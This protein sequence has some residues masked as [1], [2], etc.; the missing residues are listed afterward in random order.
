MTA[1]TGIPFDIPAANRDPSLLSEGPISLPYE[2]GIWKGLTDNRKKADYRV[3]WPTI[4]RDRKNPNS[5][6]PAPR[7]SNVILQCSPKFANSITRSS[8]EQLGIE[9]R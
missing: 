2:T 4:L 9:T 8:V 6:G 7:R 1:M 5:K 3:G